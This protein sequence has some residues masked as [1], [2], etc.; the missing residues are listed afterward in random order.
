MSKITTRLDKN[1]IIEQA[2]QRYETEQKSKLPT[3]IVSLPSRGK[4]YPADS[5]LR[6]GKIEI[7]YMTAYDEDIMTNV[8][9]VR[10]GIMFDKLLES[11]VMTDCDVTQIIP[12]DKD[13]ILIQSRILAYGAEY[14]VVVKDPKTGNELQRVVNLS[15]L[16]HK[17]FTLTPDEKGE[18][19]YKPT[20]EK[21]LTIKFSYNIKTT[22]DSGVWDMLKQC[23]KEI[24]G[25]RTWEN[26]EHF[27]KFQFLAKDSR[28]FR[29]FFME[30][31]PGLDYEYEFEGEQ[32]GT[33]SAVFPVNIDLFWF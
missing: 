17:P 5:P 27:I 28:E 8:S 26:I 31:T 19:V 20:G 22:S 29:K 32:G 9:Y 30:N 4:V 15:N 11:I 7:R 12:S 33:F 24:N 23:I 14:P 18:F 2:K 3:E 25:K 13:A 6:E 1:S 21:D 10:E 16:K